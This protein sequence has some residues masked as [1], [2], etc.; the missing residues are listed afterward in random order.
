MEAALLELR[1]SR[2][3]DARYRAVRRLC[4][5][6]KF[7]L[8]QEGGSTV[9]HLHLFGLLSARL[10]EL[11]SSPDAHDRVAAVWAV[12]ELTDM[13]LPWGEDQK[14]R[15]FSALLSDALRTTADPHA[16]RLVIRAAGQLARV[17]GTLAA[18][19]ADGE[20][21]RAL[22]SL[23]APAASEASR[24]AAVLL[25]KELIEKAP[26]YFAP[27]APMFFAH[28][29][30][31]LSDPRVAIREAA[32]RALAAALALLAARRARGREQW[33]AALY[34]TARGALAGGGLSGSSSAAAKWADTVHGAL[35]VMNELLA[36]AGGVGGGP[37]CGGEVG[38]AGEAGGG[39]AAAAAAGAAEGGGGGSSVA[40]GEG[41]MPRTP[42]PAHVA[43]VFSFMSSRFN[44]ACE[45][46]LKYKASKDRTVRA[47]VVALLPR[48][49]YLQP[50]LFVRGYAE[51]ALAH[52]L[53]T[54]RE[55]GAPARG[56]GGGR[57][58]EPSAAASDRAA[59]FLA[60]GRI[61]LAVGVHLA[62]DVLRA[63]LER[64]VG[65]L[66]EALAPA[67]GGEDAPP[68]ALHCLAMLCHAV[69]PSMTAHCLSLLD[70]LFRGGLTELVCG[71]LS[72]AFRSP[73]PSS[74]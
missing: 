61:A 39:A 16:L 9:S 36:A 31:A 58:G 43:P 68:Q 71:V 15:R 4:D 73:S 72:G 30:N 21:R 2:S 74:S 65:A 28:I 3:D 22:E 54:L 47:S 26:A 46:V 11:L 25:L 40:V 57:G 34:N 55:A 67:A 14:V 60:V 45:L 24:L 69:G 51:V 62:S 12:Y 10:A 6:V 35:L 66:R 18:D 52:L 56:G 38:G 8:R 37:G 33:C 70:L 64:V 27:H 7:D 59:A 32:A 41:S 44:E 42:P 13:T 53:S 17:G 49:A 5:A 50:E 63:Q 29:W 20:V 23:S 1:A 48:L 19:F